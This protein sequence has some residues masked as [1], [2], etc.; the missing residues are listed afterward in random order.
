MLL[1]S[2]LIFIAL[3]IFI[4][5]QMKGYVAIGIT[6]ESFQAAIQSALQKL[7]IEFEEELARIKLASLDIDLQVS[8]QS[9]IGTAQLK[10]KQSKG[11]A[12]VKEIANAIID[13][14]QTNETKT[15]NVT[16]I[17]YLV[18]GL[19]TLAMAIWFTTL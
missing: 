12:I 13:Y 16:S 10:A 1:L 3:L 14:Y 9:W 8:I 2:P 15:N 19:L 7:N 17:F 4:W 6:D 18:L 5:M 11:N